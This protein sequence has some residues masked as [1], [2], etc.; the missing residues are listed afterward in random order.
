MAQKFLTDI[1]VTR[2]LVDS[3]GDLGVAGQVLSSTG[4]GTNWIT[5][6]ANSTVV[7]LDEFTGDNSTVDFTLSVSVTDENVTQVYIDGVYQNKDTYSI[8]QDTLTFSTAPPLSA[9]IEVIT[10]ATITTSDELQAGVMII[11]VKN[12]HTASID[13]GEPVYITG[14]VGSSAR[15][16]IA[17]ADA[18]NS[19]K[20]PAAGLL[21][22]TLAVNAEGYV[23][24]GGYLR[25]ITTDTIDGTSTTSNDTVYVKAGGGLT[26]TKPTGTNL[27][28]NIAKIARSSGG[29]SGSLLVSSILR[30]NDVPNITN[31]YF[32]LG[33][34]S[35][36]ATPTEFTSTGR[37]LL[38]VGAEGTA[39]GDGNLAYNNSSGVFTYTPPVL[40]GLSGTTDDITEGSTNLYYT[41]ARAR[42]AISENSTQLSY[43]STTG[44]L[45]Y[46]QG[47]TD[48]VS[49]GATNLYY[50]D[51]RV[52]SYLT[53]NNYV[54]SSSTHT[55]TNKS[56]NISQWTNDSGYITDGNT[57]WDN[58]Y[59]F[60][61]ASSTDTLTNKSGNISMFTND[62]GYIT[63]GNTNWDNSY[64]FITASSTDTLTNK[65]GNI[66]QWTNDSGY[67]TGYTETD[68]LATVTARGASTSTTVTFSKAVF[69]T[70]S[71][72]LPRQITIKE[73]GDTENSMGSYPG[74]WTSALN[75]QSNDASTYL[76]LSPLTSNIPRIQTNYGQLDFYTG[77]NT[78]RAL[79]LS[80]TS[81]RS[82][83]FYDLNNTTYYIDAAST[84]SVNA[85]NAVGQFATTLANGFKIDSASY[86]RIE[87]DSSD[88]WSY[89]RYQDNG[90]IS[91]DVAVYDGGQYELRPA[92]QSTNVWTYTA[93]GHAQAG[94]S[95]RAPIFYDSDDTTY[96]LDPALTGK[97]L[98]IAGGISTNVANGDVIIK[99]TVSE[100]NSWIFQENAGNWG[101]FWNNEP[102]NGTAFG[103][104]TT[105]GAEFI[106]FRN[107]SATNMINPSA[108]TGINSTA[109]AAW[110]LSNYS[111]DFWTAGTQYSAVDMRAPIFYDSN[112]TAYYVNAASTS[113]LNAVQI[114]T[115][116]SNTG[117]GLQIYSTSQ[118]Q[119]PQI[120]SNAA[121]EAMW[122]Y[123]NTAA[124]W[125]VGIRT[126]S[127]LLG[128]SGFHFYNTTS[129][130]T[131]GG[132]DINGA[133]YS[134]ASSRAPIFYDS[135]NTA[136][137]TDPN[138]TTSARLFGFVKIG[139]SSTYNTDDGT[140][141]T[142]LVVAST[143]HA[144]IDCAQ[145]AN[146]VRASW[147]THTGQLYSTFGTVTS[148]EMR[149]ISYNAV[150]QILHNGYSTE[151]GSYRAPIFYDN[152]DT[153]YYIDANSTSNLNGVTIA[154]DLRVGG[155]T[156]F[157]VIPS[158]YTNADADQWP[159]IYW[160]RD[161][162]N[163]WD[164]GLIKNSS[165]RGFFSKA[166]W[167]IHM[168][169]SRAFHVFS[170]GWTANFGVEHGGN[171][172]ASGQMRAP[173][174][175]DYNDTNYYSNPNSSSR[176]HSI[177][178]GDGTPDTTPDGTAFSNTI[179]SVGGNSRVVNFEGVSGSISTWYTIGNTAYGAIDQNTSY[180]SFWQNLGSGWQEQFRIYR[181]YQQSQNQLRAPIFYDSANTSY[182]VDPNNGTSLSG[183]QLNYNCRFRASTSGTFNYS[184][185]YGFHD[186]E[187][188]SSNEPIAVFYHQ[189]GTTSVQ[190][191]GINVLSAAAHNNTT[192]RF[193]LGQG[194][195]TERI[196]I[197][198]NGNIQNSNN[199]YG[200]LSDINL[201]ENIVDATPKLDEIN[202]VRIVNFNYIGDVDEETNTP[203][204]QIGVVAQEL[205]EIFPGMVYECGDT[206]TPTKSVKY[207]VFVPMLIKAVQELTQEVQTLK[208]QI[209]GIN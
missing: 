207:S 179:K 84:S 131:V 152:N 155:T 17:P 175:Y 5:N 25:N 38:S 187:N 142:R 137:F 199:S 78:N 21:L 24:T 57:N 31:D 107:A 86:A 135:N 53:T 208:D 141:G 22:T 168:D 136:Y 183:N 4:T 150:R 123:K 39:A 10:F 52:L 122:N 30:T 166:G 138:G 112:N 164:E 205:E 46:T 116:N 129:S 32:W 80:G 165:S 27:I 188:G 26:M 139:N 95:S 209:N 132:W 108:W 65:S 23:V 157:N 151:Q 177:V 58:S 73:D 204:K 124:E 99:H 172:F 121:R 186:F 161:T 89:I 178:V 9:D 42:A 61:T 197:Y 117:G 153:A 82:E 174:F 180:M 48:T 3:D 169:S 100:A 156:K 200:Q 118:N 206:E 149:L 29:S 47:D 35:G 170:S 45:T 33:N 59:G 2:G 11:P 60:I 158:G 185:G 90:A 43:N 51:A 7:Y 66:S 77:S 103:S 50:T 34:S 104:Y 93:A 83:I 76:W 127:Q 64:G 12:T 68:T 125:Y 147:F 110:L 15:L 162:G 75:I 154:G 176:L 196:K 111:G 193:F 198:S 81:A 194:G 36:V 41:D 140:W 44:V 94:A 101:L 119:Y 159:Y 37:G 109:Y 74:A 16:Q 105:V 143:I 69:N 97:S 148:H 173:I 134:I 192:S 191:Y 6:E 190:Q 62:S 71:S 195:S 92:G 203:N 128:T 49:E 167:G 88:N 181:G 85:I 79:H 145:D 96:Y 184:T 201:K 113:I 40:G 146:A 8:A 163:G 55:F 20:M 106:G 28:Q 182:Y 1:E 120:Y 202:Q 70:S 130:Q 144:R 115:P 98:K 19:A 54:T 14:N 56:G 126:S 114:N 171:A 67:I 160:H 13:K 189:V 63:D 18:S 91:W 87:L 102:T 133:S 72:G